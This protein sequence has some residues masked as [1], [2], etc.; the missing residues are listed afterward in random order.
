MAVLQLYQKGGYN[1]SKPMSEGEGAGSDQNHQSSAGWERLLELPLQNVL[2]VRTRGNVI[3]TSATVDLWR[4]GCIFFHV[5]V[6]QTFHIWMDVVDFQEIPH[7]GAFGD[8]VWSDPEDIESWAAK[9][10]MI[11]LCLQGCMFVE[12]S[13]NRIYIYI[14]IYIYMVDHRVRFIHDSR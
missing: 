1:L 2:K 7:E 12:W 14:Y 10:S 5:A 8:I 11:R 3:T 4:S 9:A 13:F 6:V